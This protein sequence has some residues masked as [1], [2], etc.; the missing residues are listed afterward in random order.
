M[1]DEKTKTKKDMIETSPAPSTDISEE[2]PVN[3][4]HPRHPP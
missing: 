3:K 2:Q 4:Q 1:M